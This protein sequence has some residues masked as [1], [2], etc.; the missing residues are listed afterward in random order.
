[1]PLASCV[2]TI[3]LTPAKLPTLNCSEVVWPPSTLTV[4]YSRSTISPGVIVAE[5]IRIVCV[6]CGTNRNSNCPLESVRWLIR[7]SRMTSALLNPRIA[8]AL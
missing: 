3:P 2:A 6:P 5:S 8:G 7:P 4:W 1:M